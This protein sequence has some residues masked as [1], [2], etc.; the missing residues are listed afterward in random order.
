MVH[1]EP[2]ASYNDGSYF[3]ETRSTRRPNEWVK[4]DTYPRASLEVK[5][6]TLLF[7]DNIELMVLV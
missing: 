5:Y 1:G 6:F 7:K 3:I 4:R 2:L